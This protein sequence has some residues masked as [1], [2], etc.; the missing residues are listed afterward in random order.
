MGSKTIR[1]L[2]YARIS[3]IKQEDGLSKESQIELNTKLCARCQLEIDRVEQETFPAKTMERPILSKILKEIRN[4]TNT[5]NVIIVTSFDR[6]SRDVL[7][8]L[9]VSELAP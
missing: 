2:I 9:E 3:S 5:F 6:F 7:S 8:A 4:G 1:G